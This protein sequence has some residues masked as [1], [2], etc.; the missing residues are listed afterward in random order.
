[1]LN[2]EDFRNDKVIAEPFGSG[3]Y[4][5]A[6]FELTM[7]ESQ[8]TVS[9]LKYQRTQLIP[10]D[11]L[12]TLTIRYEDVNDSVVKELEFAVEE[13]L[14]ATKNIEKAITCIQLADRL[15][16]ARVDELTRKKVQRLLEFETI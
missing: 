5:T 12:G 6:L 9:D 1:M 10:S 13:T 11:E 4:F 16:S 2:H 3:S 7:N 14:P 8:E 15:R